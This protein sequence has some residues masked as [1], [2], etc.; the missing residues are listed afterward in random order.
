MTTLTLLENEFA[1]LKL[2]Q[3]TGIVHHEFH[4]FIFGEAFRTV[5][6]TGVEAMEKHKATKWL[7][8]DRKNNALPQDDAEWAMTT[9][10]T[11]TLNA[12]WKFWAVVLPQKVLGQMNMQRFIEMYKERGLEVR[13]F[14]DPALAMAWLEKA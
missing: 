8:D 12:G 5:L 1:T 6:T 13:A 2:H 10:S 7:S 14:T 9:W 3:A 4:K 11:R